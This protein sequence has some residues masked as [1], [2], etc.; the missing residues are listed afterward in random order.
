MKLRNC[1]NINHLHFML[2]L[3]FKKYVNKISYFKILKII[4][5]YHIF[6]FILV[7]GVSIFKSFSFAPRLN[8]KFA[9]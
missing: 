3:N 2:R 8:E 6:Y 9:A 4:I 7:I 5:N 1:S